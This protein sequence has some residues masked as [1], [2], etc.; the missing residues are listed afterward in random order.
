MHWEFDKELQQ[1]LI[2]VPVNVS[3]L[4]IIRREQPIAALPASIKTSTTITLCISKLGEG[5]K[6]MLTRTSKT[7]RMPHVTHISLESE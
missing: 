3:S 6:A 4:H 5:P 7:V 1:I 2:C